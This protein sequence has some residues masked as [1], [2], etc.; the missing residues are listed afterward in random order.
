MPANESIFSKFIDG[1][2]KE[3]T[4]AD[5]ANELLEWLT[6]KWPG[7][8]IS[9]RE[10]THYGPGFL[11]KDRESAY[12]TA[13]ILVQRGILVPLAPQRRDQRLWHIVRRPV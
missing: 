4:E 9:L 8:T 3:P 10:I 12:N 6:R 2:E 7:N 13:E 1:L 5:P 11:Q